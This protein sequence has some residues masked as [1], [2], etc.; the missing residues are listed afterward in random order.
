[1]RKTIII[2]HV[3]AKN[4]KYNKRKLINTV[5]YLS[6]SECKCRQLSHDF[7]PYLDS[8]Q[9]YGRV[10]KRGLWEKK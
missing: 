2:V 9:F 4:R 7:P 1:M 3:R 8:S 10:K 5:L 6:H